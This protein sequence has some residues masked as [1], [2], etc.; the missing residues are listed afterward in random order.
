M[1]EGQSADRFLTEARL[2]ASLSHRGIVPVY[3]AGTT[4]SGQCYVVSKFMEGGDLRT[5]IKTARPSFSESAMIVMQIA[6]ALSFAHERRLVHRDIKPSNL[7]MDINK[8][9]YIADFGAATREESSNAVGFVGTPAYMSPEQA[10]GES[11][12]VDART[13]IFS[14]GVVFYELLTGRRP[15]Q[16]HNVSRLLADVIANDPDPPRQIDTKIPVELERIC[17]KAMSK[18]AAARYQSALELARDL[19]IWSNGRTKSTDAA[20]TEPV[21]PK[22]L[23]S[24]DANDA[25][26]FLQLLPGPRDRE[27]M[28]ESVRFWRARIERGGSEPSFLVGVIYGPSG[29]GKSSLV[30]AGLVPS[31]GQGVLPLYV[32]ARPDS[33]EAELAQ[34]L[35][36]A[37]GILG[38]LPE[39]ARMIRRENSAVRPQNPN[40]DRSVEQWLHVQHDLSR[41]PLVQALRQCDGIHLQCLLLVRDDFW[42]PLVRFM[43]E[44]EVPLSNTRTRWRSTYSTGST[45]K[46]S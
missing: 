20:F 30:R 6:E 39:V 34:K 36:D 16:S 38:D 21:I 3:D 14:L 11:H 15:F 22:G 4:E 27:S 1:P 25:E 31:L 5:R 18:R 37:S 46:T 44:V 8:A 41:A 45:L 35:R 9:V 24:F 12:R 43:A 13:D 40:C 19:E 33:T 26:F 28:P 29:C 23:R 10:R 2:A 17:L 32:E 7:L 42:M